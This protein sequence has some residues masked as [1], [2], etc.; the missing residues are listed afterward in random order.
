MAAAAAGAAVYSTFVGSFFCLFLPG[1]NGI[2]KNKHVVCSK[3]VN[4]VQIVFNYKELIQE[5]PGGTKK[6]KYVSIL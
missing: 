5:E 6:N 4:I 2:H 1:Y 3:M